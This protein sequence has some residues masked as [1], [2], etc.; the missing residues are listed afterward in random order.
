MDDYSVVV[1]S[2][3]LR[4]VADGAIPF[5]SRWSSGGVTVQAEF[6]GGH[7]LH[8]AIAACV[9]NDLYRDAPALGVEVR[10]ARV[11]AGG[12][13]T[14]EGSTGIS[15]SIEVDSPAPPEQVSALISHVESVAEIP[16]SVRVGTT[17]GRVDP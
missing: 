14:A 16:H 5:P 8:V 7:L 2:G 6:T 3:S 12:G 4:S 15:Y 11:R 13:F 10:G 17:V 9:L 1:G